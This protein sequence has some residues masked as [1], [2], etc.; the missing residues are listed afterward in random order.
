MHG[1]SRHGPSTRSLLHNTVDFPFYYL[2]RETLT[3]SSSSFTYGKKFIP[4]S[5]YVIQF[6]NRYNN[7]TADTDT[8]ANQPDTHGNV[9]N[10][11]NTYIREERSNSKPY[12]RTTR[13]TSSKG[14][15]EK[16]REGKGR[17]TGRLIVEAEKENEGGSYVAK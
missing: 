9:G 1:I 3:S 15:E 6:G 12:A 13:T 5:H 2:I 10:I 17:S 7:R 14:R 16:G 4:Y 11:P 8:D